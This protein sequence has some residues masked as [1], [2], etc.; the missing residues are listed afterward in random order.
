VANTEAAYGLVLITLTATIT[1]DLA[2]PE[3][4]WAA[5][6][7]TLLGAV[8][9]ATTLV[10][11][12]A[13]RGMWVVLAVVVAA[14]VAVSLLRGADAVGANATS[15]LGALLITTLVLVVVARD[16]VR[17]PRITVRTLLGGIAVY[18]LIGLVF[19]RL[20]A[21]LASVNSGRFFAQPGNDSPADYLYFSY[22]TQATVGFGD[23][24]PGTRLGRAFTI[25]NALIGQLYLVTV[26]ALVVSN[27]GR[28][29]TPP[30]GR[31]ESR[32]EG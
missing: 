8:A 19:A 29:R 6:V 22:I 13:S 2:A 5:A 15:R 3:T 10:I 27:I 26:V 1:F 21:F 32:P 18:L 25:G 4:R 14:A 20:Y 31:D 23:L 16:L 24:T 12:R 17:H 30:A 9:L 11:T 7:Q 28:E